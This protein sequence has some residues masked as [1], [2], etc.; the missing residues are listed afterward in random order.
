MTASDF[1]RPAQVRS[2]GLS[3]PVACILLFLVS[4]A[5][6]LPG[7]AT[8]PPMDRDE[9][10]FAQASK[11]ML[12]TGDYVAIRFQDE[13]RN[14]KPVGI[15]WL[16]AAVVAAADHV[17]VPEARTRIWLY[18]LPS[19]AGAIA[20]V[21]LTFW[22][23]RGL[24]SPGMA[25][26]A[27]LFMAST[28]LL[29]VEARLAKTDAVL[30]AT[31]VAAM[32][33]LARIWMHHLPR[34]DWRMPLV[35]WT[36]M[37]VGLLVKGP[38][39]PMVPLLACIGLAISIRSV[40]WLGA[41]RPLWGLVWCLLIALPWFVLIMRATHGTFLSDSLGGDMLGKVASGQEAH[42]AP[43]GTYLLAFLGTAWPLS[44]FALMAA[45]FAWWERRDPAVSF[46][47]AWLVP[48]WLVFELVPTKLPHYVLPLYPAIAI[49][50][51][52]ALE[53][54]AI[55]LRRRWS[56]IAAWLLPAVP[57]V[58]V[59]ACLGAVVWFHISP[60]WLFILAASAALLQVVTTGQAILQRDRS[61]LMSGSLGL[62]LATYIT[63]WAGAFGGPLFGPF[64]LSERLVAAR[65]HALGLAPT[66]ASLTAATTSYREPSLVMTDAAGAAAFLAGGSCRVAFVPARDE[67]AFR[68]AGGDPAH[69]QLVDRVAGINLNGGR[70]LDIGVYL[71]QG[72]G[73]DPSAAR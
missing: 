6:F 2:S 55:D 23:A 33:V 56:S 63:V 47:L 26:V 49:L 24:G 54:G 45:P 9:P 10:R 30:A 12:E 60:G 48:A 40:R 73:D 35:F 18:R 1:F 64:D 67:A 59:L 3:G 41:L 65:Q 15:Y 8:L 52:V 22:A 29:G 5:M 28:V 11:Q 38:I 70:A 61:R 16:Q 32:G 7:F 36:A 31:I 21:L 71:G 44:P 58:L 39:T 20:T 69:T 66:C 4:C 62:A 42:G 25:F 68:A 34:R 46:L 53:R 57:L 43:P 19:L 50:T 13:A 14:K 51:A 17:G 72:G 27:G 37:G